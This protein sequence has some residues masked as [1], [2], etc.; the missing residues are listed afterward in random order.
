M[1]GFIVASFGKFFLIIPVAL[2]CKSRSLLYPGTIS[3]LRW[4]DNLGSKGSM[5]PAASPVR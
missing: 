2:L 4:S 5:I 3:D 1:Y